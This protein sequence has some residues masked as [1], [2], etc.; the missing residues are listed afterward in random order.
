M[1]G[2]EF[3]SYADSVSLV[4]VIASVCGY[5]CCPTLPIYTAAKHGVVGFVRSY[6]KYLPEEK[7]TLN[8][9]TPNVIR[10]NISTAQFYDTLEEKGLLTP[11]EGVVDAFERLIDSDESGE[12]FESGPNYAKGQG[13]VTP[14]FIQ[15]VDKESKEVFD[16]LEQR[17][18]PLQR[19]G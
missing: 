3:V 11:I 18:K 4:G 10:T 16:M 12:C 17:G 15:Y 13:M 14:K 1:A 7:I 8:A 2:L 5:Y 9:V 19:P 6:G